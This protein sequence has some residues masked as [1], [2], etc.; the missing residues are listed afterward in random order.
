MT[1]DGVLRTV[2]SLLDNQP[3][4]HEP[5]QQHHPEYSEFVRYTTWRWLLLDYLEK[6]T[7]PG[8]KAWLQKYV[9]KKGDKMMEELLRQQALPGPLPA[10]T[11]R[12]AVSARPYNHKE[13]AVDYPLLIQ[14][15]Q[16]AIQSSKAAQH[17]V[18]S[19][20]DKLDD[21]SA[22]PE[23]SPE[24]PPTCPTKKMKTTDITGIVPGGSSKARTTA[25]RK[26]T[27]EYQ[28]HSS[29]TA[30]Q[31]MALAG[32]Q[33]KA[34]TEQSEPSSKRIKKKNVEVIDLT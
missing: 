11:T 23:S 33:A 6:E 24:N 20:N 7:H 28:M 5:G 8:A 27:A 25:K 18:V 10:R 9:A 29:Q 13:V 4:T 3:Y 32:Q 26:I 2:Q 16:S 14:Q 21:A 17:P 1:T 12:K 22:P 34:P 15:L 30:T 31:T 19:V